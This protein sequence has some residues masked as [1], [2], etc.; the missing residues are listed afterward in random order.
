MIP[1]RV[2][3]F[4]SRIPGYQTMQMWPH[5]SL[6]GASKSFVPYEVQNTNMSKAKKKE[7]KNHKLQLHCMLLK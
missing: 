1:N 6:L 5:K 2:N 3:I 4:Y 7:N